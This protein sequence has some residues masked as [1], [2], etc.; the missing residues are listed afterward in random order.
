ML[1]SQAISRIA[2]LGC[3]KA[4]ALHTDILQFDAADFSK[5]VVSY[6]NMRT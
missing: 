3:R 4:Q 5:R 6:T 1:D 2:E